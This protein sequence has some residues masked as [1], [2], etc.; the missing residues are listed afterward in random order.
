MVTGLT[1]REGRVGEMLTMADKGG[2]GGWGNADNGWQRG[3]GGS[4]PPH[5]W[6]I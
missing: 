6:L 1:K 5:L 3:K 4:G 2:M